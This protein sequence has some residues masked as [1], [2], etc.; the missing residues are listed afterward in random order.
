V[1]FAAFIPLIAAGV[2]AAAS[3]FTQNKQNKENRR[4]A[5]YQNEANQEYLQQQLAYNTPAQQVARYQSAGLN[6]NLVYGQTNAGNQQQ[7]LTHPDI[8]P[9][10]YSAMM[11]LVPLAN[12]TAMTVSQVQ[13]QNATTRQKTVMTELNRLQAKVLARN[14]ALNDDAYKAMI[15]SLK[16]AAEIKA[17]ESAQSQMTTKWME[18][19]AYVDKG[20]GTVEIT[21]NGYVKMDKELQLL[22]QRFRLGELDAKLKSEVMTSK[23]FQNAI[24]EVQKKFMTDGDITPQHILT[25]IQLLLMKA[26]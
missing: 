18:T 9:T 11:N 14:P 24:L 16:S 21:Y 6:P 8:K 13:A 5:E 22:E 3:I 19:Q 12:Q 7:P 10:D 2:Q 4:L 25:F 26:L 17:S 15:D 1:P 20:G 23:E